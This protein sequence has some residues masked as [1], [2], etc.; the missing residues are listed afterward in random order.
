MAHSPFARGQRCYRC[1]RRLLG[2]GH[3]LCPEP[4]YAAVSSGIEDYVVGQFFGQ[5]E[6]L[7]VEPF[8][9]SSELAQVEDEI[10]AAEPDLGVYGDDARI[11]DA[12][13]ADR[14]VAGL[15]QRRATLDQLLRRRAE[16][17][18]ASDRADGLNPVE[19][20][21]LWPELTV[22]ERRRLLRSVSSVCSYAAGEPG[23]IPSPASSGSAGGERRP[24]SPAAGRRGTSHSPPSDYRTRQRTPGWRRARNSTSSSAA[25]RRACLRAAEFTLPRRLAAG[26][27]PPR[28]PRAV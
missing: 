19:L 28:R 24:T 3:A 12:L 1:H 13:G 23:T 16:L 4:A 6:R 17:E 26:R 5:L 20:R 25:S 11:A 15:E 2:P 27:R 10:R 18:A 21:E 9:D 8:E 7:E 14:Y 22:D